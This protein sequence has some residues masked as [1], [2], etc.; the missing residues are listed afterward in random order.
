MHEGLVMGPV[1]TGTQD[2]H[3]LDMGS[4]RLRRPASDVA[5]RAGNDGHAVTSPDQIA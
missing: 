5:D 2:R 4:L 1:H 3:P